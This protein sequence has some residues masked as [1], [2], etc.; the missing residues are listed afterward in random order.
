MA[1]SEAIAD[2]LVE[3]IRE[4]AEAQAD[5][6]AIS[7]VFERA[8]SRMRDADAGSVWIKELDRLERRLIR[9]VKRRS[10]A[11]ADER[12]RRLQVC[13]EVLLT[14]LEEDR[15]DSGTGDQT[16]SGPPS[17]W[18]TLTAMF[19]LL[20]RGDGGPLGKLVSNSGLRRLV[21]R[22]QQSDSPSV[23]KKER[24]SP[25]EYLEKYDP[26]F[27]PG[28]FLV[29]WRWWLG[30]VG[31]VLVMVYFPW[32]VIADATPARGLI[33]FMSELFPLIKGI[34]ADARH[35]PVPA[36]ELQL[37]VLY[38]FCMAVVVF[39]LIIQPRPV[40]WEK[41]S[42]KSL[43]QI[44]FVTLGLAVGVFAVMVMISGQHID[45][46]DSYGF[47]NTRFGVVIIHSLILW[48]FP[49]IMLCF[50]KAAVQELLRRVNEKRTD[51]SNT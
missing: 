19:V 47:Y 38:L 4:L 26:Q 37:S 41:F 36:S 1:D 35:R 30:Y 8:K 2:A 42:K 7:D 11:Q 44:S 39:H 31:F 15:K 48:G 28:A 46:D 13:L 10:Q 24:L 43:Y 45:P 3:L 23:E 21:Q 17:T 51:G 5:E 12:V 18:T 40:G 16:G 33:E 29:N 6:R 22:Q 25:R 49:L 14:G 9:D 34:P 50:C 20:G 27:A 32:H